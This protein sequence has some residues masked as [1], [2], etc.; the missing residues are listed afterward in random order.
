MNLA[1]L[2]DDHV[3]DYGDHEETSS[4]VAGTR[5]LRPRKAKNWER[6]AGAGGRARE[7]RVVVLLPNCPRLASPTGDRGVSVRPVTPVIFMLPPPEIHRILEQSEAKVAITSPDFL[8]NL[9]T[10]AQ[11]VETLERIVCVS[12]GDRRRKRSPA[13]ATVLRRAR[14]WRTVARWSRA[15]WAV[16][17]TR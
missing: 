14:R 16:C 10:A 9:Q 6:D 12:D 11:G 17:S 15:P 8:A 1:R 7:N 2:L 13:R 5:R 3:R 4:K